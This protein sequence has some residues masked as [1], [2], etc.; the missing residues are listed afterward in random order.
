VGSAVVAELDSE[1]VLQRVLEAARELTGARY[2]ALGVLDAQRRELER[3]ITA[4]IGE[5]DRRRI[6]DLPRGRGILGLLIDDPSPLRLAEVGSHPESYGFPAGHPPMS[7]FLGVPILVRGEAWGNL[8][9]TEKEGGA[10]FDESDEETIVVLARWAATA[11]ENARLY[12]SE[13]SQRTELQRAVRALETTR[14]ITRALGSETDLE[15][16]L[17]LIVK[18]GRAL[19]DARSM[20]ILLAQGDQLTVAAAAGGLAQDVVGVK[21]PVD[22]SAA[23]EVFRTGRPERLSEVSTRLRFRLAEH[24]DA[25][26]GLFVP[27]VFRSRRLGVLAAFDRTTETTEFDTEDERIMDA[28]A[29]AA[30]TAV[31]TAQDVAAQSL[32]RSIHASEQERARW[33]RELHDETL[34]ELGGLKLTLSAARRMDDFDQVRDALAGAVEQVSNSIAQLRH[35]ITELRPASLDELGTQPALEALVDRVKAT[36]GLEVELQ[37]D[38]AYEAGRAALRHAPALETTIYRVVQEA[39]TNVIKHA[40]AEHVEIAVIE[41]EDTVEIGVRDDGAGFDP[42]ARADGFGMVGMRERVALA[43]GTLRIDSAPG[44]GTRVRA[45]VPV[46]LAEPLASVDRLAG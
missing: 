42:T 17:E 10:E 1:V 24:V 11:I 3:F 19:V 13:R 20:V 4:G 30:A 18:R 7:T 36:T 29:A 22:D 38:L 34:Q 5:D 33:A 15:R 44:K 26:T 16:V 25:Q 37:L 41:L 6:G 2:A 40:Q 12:R 23:G 35:L 14:A 43:G 46:V 8:Y 45:S 28:F 27:L 39:L 31:A 21:I 32:Q 9:L